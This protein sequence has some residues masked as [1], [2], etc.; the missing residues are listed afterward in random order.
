MNEADSVEPSE[1]AS[2]LRDL[3]LEGA[4]GFNINFGEHGHNEG[5]QMV[6]NNW[7]MED[8]ELQSKNE[9]ISDPIPSQ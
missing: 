7:V 1:I 4:N 9:F 5:F 2:A 6:V 3:N 8:G